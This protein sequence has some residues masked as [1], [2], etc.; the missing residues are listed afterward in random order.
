MSFFRRE[1]E[2][3]ASGAVMTT[4]YEARLEF[5]CHVLP[6]TLPEDRADS[7]DT[8]VERLVHQGRAD[9]DAVQTWRNPYR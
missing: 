7:W 9:M 2:S 5:E 8:F 4:H 3:P 1:K 6:H